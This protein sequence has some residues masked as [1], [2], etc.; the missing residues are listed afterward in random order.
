LFIFNPRP[1]G[2]PHSADNI[3]LIKFQLVCKRVNLGKNKFSD[4][5]FR[6]WAKAAFTWSGRPCS[7]QDVKHSR[8]DN[9]DAEDEEE[10]EEYA[11][12]AEEAEEWCGGDD[13]EE[14]M[15]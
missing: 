5:E 1:P 2:L 6:V 9:E 11:E 7:L 3:Q 15:E 8:N 14:C 10:A 12:E 4:E 13:W